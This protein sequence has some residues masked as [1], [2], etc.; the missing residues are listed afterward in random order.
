MEVFINDDV[1][2][3]VAEILGCIMVGDISVNATDVG[4]AETFLI[5]APIYRREIQRDQ[6]VNIV[7]YVD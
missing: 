5:P 6:V 7:Q 4:G 2:S 1:S 3:Y